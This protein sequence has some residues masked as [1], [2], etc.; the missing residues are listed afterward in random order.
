MSIKLND[1]AFTVPEEVTYR[2]YY[3]LSK[4]LDGVDLNSFRKKNDN[5]ENVIDV[6]AI[7][8][9]LF[10]EHKI[11]K[12]FATLLVPS[13]EST[14]KPSFAKDN[15][16]LF[17]DI[18]DVSGTEVIQDFLSGRG[19]LIQSILDYFLNFLT[20]NEELNQKLSPSKEVPPPKK[21]VSEE[22]K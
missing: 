17:M 13:G 9:V 16:E 15:E 2:Q 5:G 6:Q 14:W 11:P 22:K 12:F 4:L 21:E 18:G 7:K 3:E 10:K 20:K 8:D 19:N 1:K